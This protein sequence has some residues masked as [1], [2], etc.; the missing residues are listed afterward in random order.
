MNIERNEKKEVDM[1][2]K[3]AASLISAVLVFVFGLF[4]A[5]EVPAGDVDV[6]IGIGIGVPPPRLVV[7]T[8]PSVYLIP[9]SYVY[10][11]PDLGAQIFFY[12]GY[13]YLMD[14]GYWFRASHYRGP[15]NYLSPSRVPVVFL[16]LPRDYYR[17]PPGQ[18]LIPYGQLKKHW[19]EWD[20]QHRGDLRDWERS[21][22]ERWKKDSK[23][24][25][26]WKK[27]K[28]GKGKH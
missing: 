2:R 12:S 14:D 18:K 25:K 1:K 21:Y 3:I 26:E 11:A 28:P 6:N 7:P 9:G 5:G 23:G 10:Y 24:W 17:V 27:G 22:H 4:Q 13:W 15:W 20:R 16:H 19:K 8:P